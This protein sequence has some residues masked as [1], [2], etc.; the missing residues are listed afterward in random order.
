MTCRRPWRRPATPVAA[1]CCST[2]RRS[3]TSRPWRR[4]ATACPAS[5]RCS[6]PSR[7]RG[8]SSARSPTRA[9]W[10][11]HHGTDPAGPVRLDHRERAGRPAHAG[12]PPA[13]RAVD[14]DGV[15]DLPGERGAP[16]PRG[17]DGALE[18]VASARPLPVT[19][20]VD[21]EGHDRATA[22]CLALARRLADLTDEA[23]LV[24][25]VRARFGHGEVVPSPGPAR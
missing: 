23:D 17:P 7:R 12:E 6:S 9:D 5:R 13:Y 20:D 2:R 1:L 14:L 3:A 15:A 25:M 10:V 16:G 24:A 4:P 21:P 11:A 22:D 18:R 8:C 19:D